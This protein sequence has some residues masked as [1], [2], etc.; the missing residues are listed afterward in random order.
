MGAFDDVEARSP[1]RSMLGRGLGEAKR[2]IV[3]IIFIAFFLL[4]T[5]VAFRRQDDIKDVVST[6]LHRANTT[7]PTKSTVSETKASLGSDGKSD[8]FKTDSKAAVKSDGKTDTKADTK[9]SKTSIW[10]G[11]K[12]P[13][14]GPKLGN[15]DRTLAAS[16]IED[17]HNSTLGV[18]QISERW[19][20]V[21][22]G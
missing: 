1:T 2:R 4:L 20:E 18:C 21:T 15:G 16:S 13:S 17:I 8:T 22:D 6:S 14:Q 5:L 3:L 10:G 11:K 12:A 9:A 19:K 7:T